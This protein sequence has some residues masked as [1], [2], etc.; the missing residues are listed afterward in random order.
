VEPH[1]DPEARIREL[2][3]PLADKARATE[4]GVSQ[5]GSG[6]TRTPGP[7]PGQYVAPSAATPRKG[8]MLGWWVLGLIVALVILGAVGAVIFSTMIFTRGQPGILHDVSTAQPD[9]PLSVS[10]VDENRKIVCNDGTVNVSGVRNTVTITGHCVRLTVSGVENLV[11]VDSA[12]TIG[13]SGFDNQVTYQSGSPQI[14]SGGD[15]VVQ[16]G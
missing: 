5:Y 15:N 16:Q 6:D 13:A 10:G 8:F 3:R 9:K 4:M 1:D 14:D 11:T 2:E 12:D 7:W